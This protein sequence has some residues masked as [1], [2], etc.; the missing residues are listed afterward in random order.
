M[1][2]ADASSGNSS[3]PGRVS[4]E[5]YEYSYEYGYE[6]ALDD[7]AMIDVDRLDI[8]YVDDLALAADDDD[9]DDEFDPDVVEFGLDRQ[10]DETSSHR[11]RRPHHA[12]YD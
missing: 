8:E 7:E 1:C 5:G 3:V 9:E 10:R 2:D 6:T 11:R 12:R 4:S